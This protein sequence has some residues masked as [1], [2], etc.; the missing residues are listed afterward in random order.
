MWWVIDLIL[1]YSS[2]FFAFSPFEADQ[3]IRAKQM[4]KNINNAPS[5]HKYFKLQ[6]MNFSL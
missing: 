3:R 6:H 4:V 5:P 1:S 2:L